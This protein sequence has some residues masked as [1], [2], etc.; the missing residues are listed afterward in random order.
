MFDFGQGVAKDDAEAVRWYRL[1]AAQG[2]AGAQFNLGNMFAKGR[3][4]AKDDAEAVR[5]W[6]LAAAQ[7]HVSAQEFITRF[8]TKL[9]IPPEMV[10]KLMEQHGIR[11]GALLEEM[12]G[13]SIFDSL[14]AKANGAFNSVKDGASG[15][16][17][18][19]SKNMPDMSGVRRA[20]GKIF[21]DSFQRH[22]PD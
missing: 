9:S 22:L 2:H 11:D 18:T 16:A 13:S 7:G 4:V 15:W 21:P 20:V 12:E 1:A 3:C 17:D 19:I 14:K 10:F 6:C 5:W 8:Q